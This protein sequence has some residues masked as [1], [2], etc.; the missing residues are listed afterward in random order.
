MS[1]FTG[2]L[3][4]TRRETSFDLVAE[5]IDLHRLP[6]E[7]L[8][9]FKLRVLDAYIRPANSTYEGTINAVNR[10]TGNVAIDGDARG[11]LIDVA[12]DADGDPISLTPGLECDAKYMT[13]YSDHDN[14]T[15]EFQLDLTD[16]STTYFVSDLLTAINTSTIFDAVQLEGDDYDKSSHLVHTSSKKLAKQQRLVPGGQLQHLTEVK[17]GNYVTGNLVF[18]EVMGLTTEV[19]STPDDDDE[20]MVDYVNGAFWTS[21]PLGGR[22]TYWYQA[23]PLFIRWSPVSVFRFK[24]DEYLDNVTEQVLDADT[25]TVDG[26]PT[27]DGADLVNELLAVTPMYWGE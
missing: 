15:V 7:S 24:D 13:L 10:E 12:R 8:P 26:I 6:G 25:T 20:F 4:R 19:V 23:F 1:D 3:A 5:L 17:S 27:V 9:D 14:A 21:R 11:I 2:T 16:R 18:P 22:V